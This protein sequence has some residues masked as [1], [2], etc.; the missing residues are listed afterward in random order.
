M[1]QYCVCSACGA[2]RLAS[3]RGHMGRPS[4]VEWPR[5]RYRRWRPRHQPLH[6]LSWERCAFERR[7]LHRRVNRRAGRAEHG[8]QYSQTVGIRPRSLP[9]RA[10][11]TRPGSI[12]SGEPLSKLQV[13]C[14]VHRH[15]F[16]ATRSDAQETARGGA[17]PPPPP[18]P[19][20]STAPYCTAKQ[21]AFSL[22][23]TRDPHPL[24]PLD[25]HLSHLHL[26]QLGRSI[27]L[28]GS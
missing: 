28:V 17:P 12:S 27:Q 4:T 3:G 25:F 26:F 22:C 24:R 7:F 14:K 23:C 20:P 11:S 16:P 8:Q 9:R 10:E 13:A 5:L 15:R 18:A 19:P 21:T 6:C 2:P 1:C